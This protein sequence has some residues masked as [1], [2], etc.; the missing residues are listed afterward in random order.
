MKKLTYRG[1][2]CIIRC[3]KQYL[4]INILAY[5]WPLE[6]KTPI[7]HFGFYKYLVYYCVQKLKCNASS[8]RSYLETFQVDYFKKLLRLLDCLHIYVCALHGNAIAK[9]FRL[10]KNNQFKLN[11]VFPLILILT[12]LFNQSD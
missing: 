2:Y 7:I 4:S 6:W 5:I 10:F 1:A 11:Y 9:I 3:R 12:W 8:L